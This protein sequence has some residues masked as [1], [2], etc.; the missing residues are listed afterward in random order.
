MPP[1]WRGC[2]VHGSG[3]CRVRWTEGDGYVR[4]LYPCQVEENSGDEERSEQ[5]RP[6]KEVERKGKTTA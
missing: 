1:H 4:W 3:G 2:T 6:K 5:K